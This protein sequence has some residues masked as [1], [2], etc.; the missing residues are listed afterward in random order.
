MGEVNTFQTIKLP[1]SIWHLVQK[2]M[3]RDQLNF[4]EA[5]ARLIRYGEAYREK[6]FEVTA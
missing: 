6:T 5:I 3:D 1:L 2:E 4:S